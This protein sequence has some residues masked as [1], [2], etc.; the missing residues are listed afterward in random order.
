MGD[1]VSC[2]VTAVGDDF[3]S[4]CLA[5]GVTATASGNLATGQLSDTDLVLP[6]AASVLPMFRYP[7]RL[8]GIFR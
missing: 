4:L 8:P 2:Q 7:F 1:L 3:V 5:D 6:S